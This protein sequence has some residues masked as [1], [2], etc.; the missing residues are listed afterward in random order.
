MGPA[1]KHDEYEIERALARAGMD[2]EALASD[3]L[4]VITR[5]GAP[6][7]IVTMRPEHRVKRP[8]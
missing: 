7:M 1:V 6:S 4:R 8:G 3:T 2:V 5:P